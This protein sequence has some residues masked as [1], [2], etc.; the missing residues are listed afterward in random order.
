MGDLACFHSLF[1]QRIYLSPVLTREIV[2]PRQSNTELIRPEIRA[3]P[4]LDPDPLTK[5]SGTSPPDRLAEKGSRRV[6]HFTPVEFQSRRWVGRSK[7]LRLI[8]FATNPKRVTALGLS[9]GLIWSAGAAGES[10]PIWEQ[11]AGYRVAPLTVAPGHPSGL[12]PMSSDVTGIRFTN[13]LSEARV[14]QNHI[15]D[16]GSGVALGDIDGDG[17]CDIYLCSL[18]GTNALYRNLGNWKF[19]EIT[20]RA[21][22]AC[23]G[24]AST[25][26]VFAD[27]D[28]DGD[29]DLLVN[30]LG[31]GTRLFLNDGHGQF[32]ES[33][34]SGLLPHGGSHSMALADI[35][36][37]GFLDLYVVNYRSSS[38]KDWDQSTK[39]RLRSV[40]GRLVVPPEHAEQFTVAVTPNGN[41]LVEVGEPDQ[42][43]WNDGKGHF[44][45]Q[46]WTSGRFLDDAG[47]PLRAPLRDWGL[48]AQF[49]DINGDGFPDLYVCNDFFS[50]DRIWLNDGSGHFRPI[51][52]LALRK[53]SFASMAVDFGDLNRDGQVDFMTVDMLS[54]NQTQ[55]KVQRS[56]FELD[57]LPWWGW[58]Q[59]REGAFA[60]PQV[61][62]NTLFANR[63][64]G[65]FAEVAYA[66]G[67]FASEWSWGCVFLDVDL[68][69][70]EDVLICN[71]H[72][73]D[74]TD[75]DALLALST[76]A[77]NEPKPRFPVLT[78]PH[79]AFRNLGNFHFEEMGKA[80]GFDLQGV[81]QG[82]AMADLD[83]DG[84]L[85]VVI[86]NLNS[87]ATVLR[88]EGSGR[89][90]AVRLKGQWG[91]TQGIGAKLKL[92]GGPVEQT[93]EVI[94]GGRY[95]S[96]ADPLRVFAAGD[97]TNL[98]LE[99]S[100]RSGKRSLIQGLHGN[101]LVEVDEAGAEPV[102][103]PK[104][105]I[106]EPCFEDVSARMGVVHH[107]EPF[108]DF[109]RQPL[110]PW[111]LSQ[112]GPGLAWFDL[113]G[114]G[115]DD[116]IVGSGRG[117]HLRVLAGNGKGGFGEIRNEALDRTIPDDLSGIVAWSAEAGSASIRVGLG[118]HETGQTNQ[119]SVL[120]YDVFFGE[121]K[122]GPELPGGNSSTG[123][124]A[125]ADIDGD[126]DL[127]LFV[128]GRLIGGQYPKAARS[129]LYRNENGQFVLDQANSQKLKDIGLVSG[130]VWTDL[131]GDGFPELVLACEWGPVR[132][133]ANHHGTLS[134]VTQAWGLDKYR[135]LWT[136]VTAGDFDGDGR[137]D[138]VVGNWGRNTVYEEVIG[139]EL[140]LYH[141]DIDDNG[142]W[143]VIEAQWDPRLG[144]VVPRR[145]WKTVGQAI[146][147]VQERFNRYAD[148]A[149]A[150][151]EEIFGTKLASLQELRVN[152]LD[153]MHFLNRG[154][155]FEPK[156]LP[157]EAQLAPVFGLCVGDYDGDGKEDLFL[158][159]N[160]F[161]TDRETGR[162]DAGRG[163]WLQGD[164]QGG[165]RS[166][167]G[168]ESGVKIYGE[169]RGAALSDFDGDGRVD[170][171]VSQNGA[172]VQLYR[173]RLGRPGLR[174]RL[175]GPAGNLTGLGAVL[176]LGTVGKPGPAR[177]LH[178]GGGYWSQDSSVT[179]LAKPQEPGPWV[180]TV[181]WPGGRQTQHPVTFD[182]QEIQANFDGP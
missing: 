181:R 28:G 167:P 4:A 49:H 113:N 14:Q 68:D 92:I 123:P 54:R 46:S 79:V 43:Y 115:I 94:S 40:N 39:V 157:F 129:R 19:E 83:N 64:D 125:L 144:K 182:T 168:Q 63:G 21:G 71:G 110:L 127:D 120:G 57:P 73:H 24:Q 97:G 65:T 150:S 130:A 1:G 18:S 34:D 162:Y 169:Q 136:G 166:V 3:V 108:D 134:E 155:K 124:L 147:L 58:P 51:P 111:R 105:Q 33:F 38:F 36:G 132:I 117:G 165:W 69:G 116:L 31:G 173:N 128:G 23:P 142:T 101:E 52:R 81:S 56:N 174:V 78:P 145:D 50:P 159:Q 95:L 10:E 35:D 89:R 41:A 82:M 72:G 103:I 27:V 6:I 20:D 55:R 148:Y 175:T 158:A 119:P 84:D 149:R 112:L 160:F 86:N 114:D 87:G 25:G 107:E 161:G 53:S 131:D 7:F 61:F 143:D 139:Q 164:G 59:D 93:Q 67:V 177:E 2:A 62:R 180:L 100:W 176:R 140:R 32:K 5:L 85:D 178:G 122:A 11:N 170:L 80:W 102:G 70:Y 156:P 153:S 48:S 126:G 151:V 99:V 91:N 74:L 60:R 37:D 118:N 154:G 42:L 8:S 22:I 121:L 45:P 90:V 141:G 96:G 163:Q 88:N 77:R 16:N 104:K 109:A 26:A 13:Q 12:L 138:L 133:F 179:V 30:S 146:P 137:M 44:V 9:M 172:A 47:A 17:R 15:L 171:A 152:T 106:P 76:A 66:G 98:T 75:S 135:G 29:L